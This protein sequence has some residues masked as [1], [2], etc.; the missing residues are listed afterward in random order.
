MKAK[1]TFVFIS[2]FLLFSAVA[3]KAFYVQVI[4]RDKLIA[5]SHSQIMRETKSYP[6]RGH[7]LDRTGE[8]LAINIQ[9]YNLFTFGKNLPTF[10]KE[11]AEVKRIIPDLDINKI[12]KD[13]SKRKKFTWISRKVEIEDE[14][15]EKLKKLKTIVLETQSSRFYPNHELLSQTLGFVGVDN[16][17]LSGVEYYF[18]ERLKGEAIIRKYFK[19]AKGRPVKYK[20]SI[21]DH[22]AE[23][24]TLSID[25]DIQASLEEYLKVG[26]EKAKAHMG[27]AAVMDAETGEIWAIA[28][29]PTFDPNDIKPKDRNHLKLSFITDPFEPG[30]IF[31]TLTVASAMENKIVRDDTNY[32]CE[33]G[34][35]KVGKHII[36]ESDSNH[37]FEW[38]SVEDILKYSS[39]IGTTKIAFDLT[40]PY[41]YKTLKK[42]GIGDK[43]GVE[44]PGESRGILDELDN[45]APIRLSNIS[46]GQ[47]VATT[48]IQMLKSYAIIANGGFEVTP[49]I[50]KQKKV[51][52]KKRILSKDTVSK[53]TSILI[54][55]VDE[56]TGSKAK[57]KHFKIAGKTSTAQRPDES[58]SYSGY[59][60][61]FIGYPVNVNKRFV[62]FTYIDNPQGQYYGNL[63]AAPIFQKI[64]KNILY[65]RKEF[66]Q[67]ADKGESNSSDI[68]K[69]KATSKRSIVRG[70]IP[71]LIGLDKVSAKKILNSLGVEYNFTGFGVVREQYPQ[72]GTKIS[73]NTIL[74]LKF[75]PPKYE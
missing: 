15:I 41:L 52:K 25:K 10:K 8:P 65:K 28:N 74:K 57:I 44:V 59:V 37:S 3:I 1:T 13:V 6:K 20:S 14:H 68:V 50:I 45:V 56:G 33:R 30:S 5:Y 4:N 64:T 36:T 53:L 18:N 60:S 54:K 35:L 62:V 12:V 43:T 39:N 66:K 73:K 2:I 49:T 47:G 26:V 46:F 22:S 70:E 42:F 11:L 72:S 71:N 38:L 7:I 31:K 69:I 67:L 63:V 48:G 19:D 23:D 34:R 40:Y 32:F 61:G 17:G 27:G 55:A 29:Y 24:I 16:E 58:G 51:L 9:K 21:L 75:A